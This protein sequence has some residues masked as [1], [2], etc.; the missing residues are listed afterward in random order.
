[1]TTLRPRR[2]R[3]RLGR[4]RHA[5]PPEVR[6]RCRSTFRCSSRCTRQDTAAERRLRGQAPEMAGRR[7]GACEHAGDRDDALDLSRGPG[8]GRGVHPVRH[9][10]PSSRRGQRRRPTS[11]LATLGRRRR[12]L[13]RGE[14]ELAAAARGAS[15]FGPDRARA[16]GLAAVPRRAEARLEAI[17]GEVERWTPGQGRL[18]PAA[19]VDPPPR[20]RTSGSIS[21]ACS[22]R[23]WAPRRG[24]PLRE[25]AGEAARL[26]A[27]A[28]RWCGVSAGPS[29]PMWPR[30]RA[31]TNERRSTLL[32]E[33]RGEVPFELIT[34]AVLLRRARPVPAEPAAVP[35]GTRRR[36]RCGW[37]RTGSRERPESCT[38]SRRPICCAPRSSSGWETRKRRQSSTRASSPCGARAMPHC[39]RSSRGP[40]RSWPGWSGSRARGRARRVGSC[41]GRSRGAPRSPR[42]RLQAGP[43]PRGAV[44]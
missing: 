6:H 16:G 9:R 35:G 5:D 44:A 26:A 3:G 40:G 23:G 2:A 11:S 28:R 37:S 13:E 25:R 24:D 12:A 18:E 29:E 21:S 41:R 42:E 15:R 39:V 10:E 19:G 20:R 43:P 14:A 7:A 32:D 31:G 30:S 34:A 33:V 27:D 22:A 36:R 38:T 1:M 4:S 8:T 17:R